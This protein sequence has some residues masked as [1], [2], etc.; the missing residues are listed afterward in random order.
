[1]KLAFR[2]SLLLF[3]SVVVIAG[4]MPPV[5]AEDSGG[6]FD[7]S[8]EVKTFLKEDSEAAGGGDMGWI[9]TEMNFL[10]TLAA[11]GYD[12]L[13]EK[14]LKMMQ[15]G[16]APVTKRNKLTE[17]AKQYL[18]NASVKLMLQQI[19]QTENIREKMV[20]SRKAI[21]LARKVAKSMPAEKVVVYENGMK[22][23]SDVYLRL[24]KHFADLV[25]KEAPFGRAGDIDKA[26]GKIA[27]GPVDIDVLFD[28]E[29]AKAPDPKVAAQNAKL[30]YTGKNLTK[31]AQ[32]L[33][34]MGFRVALPVHEKINLRF[35]N[36]LE[37]YFASQDEKM[38]EQIQNA[39]KSAAVRHGGR[40]VE[41]QH[42]MESGFASWIGLY[43]Y[44]SKKSREIATSFKEFAGSIVMDYESYWRGDKS[45]YLS[46]IRVLGQE[47][48]PILEE[49]DGIMVE[50]YEE[51]EEDTSPFRYNWAPDLAKML[52]E[53]KIITSKQPESEID[54][55]F[56]RQGIY[57]YLEALIRQEDALSTRVETEKD[58][59]RLAAI[60]EY[61]GEVRKRLGALM[62]DALQPESV[63]GPM[64]ENTINNIRLKL[65]TDS[66]IR[67]AERAKKH[68]QKDNVIENL[69]KALAEC[70]AVVSQTKSQSWKVAAKDMIPHIQEY[71]VKLLGEPLIDLTAML[72]QLEEN[73]NKS[74]DAKLKPNEK[75]DALV[76]T[77]ESGFD[78]I[79]GL[80][81]YPDDKARRAEFLPKALLW[82]GMASIELKDFE[83]AYL[84]DLALVQEFTPMRYPRKKYEGVDKS[85]DTATQHLLFAANQMNKLN[86]SSERAKDL[87][88]LALEDVI[89]SVPDPDPAQFVQFINLKKKR[90]K[91]AQALQFVESI[92]EDNIY[93]RTV[94]LLGAGIYNDKI[95]LSRKELAAV[96]KQLA[97]SDGKG[98]GVSASA[99]AEFDAKVADLQKQIAADRENALSYCKRFHAEHDAAAAKR[100]Q[101]IENGKVFSKSD[102]AV[103]LKECEQVLAA[104]LIPIKIMLDSEEYG[105]VVPRIRQFIQ[106]AS[107]QAN[108]DKDKRQKYIAD[109]TYYL[110]VATY[111]A[112]GHDATVAID[113]RAAALKAAEGVRDQLQKVDTERKYE[114][115][116]ASLLGSGYLKL[117]TDVAAKRAELE[118]GGQDGAALKAQEDEF[119]VSGVK[120]FSRAEGLV[121]RDMDRALQMGEI[122]TEQ[123]MYPQAEA[124]YEK[125]VAFWSDSL[126]ADAEVCLFQPEKGMK[127]LA[128]LSAPAWLPLGKAKDAQTPD[129]AAKILNAFIKTNRCTPENM[130]D[131]RAV[132]DAVKG[133]ASGDLKKNIEQAETILARVGAKAPLTEQA[134]YKLN[135]VVLEAAAPNVLYWSRPVY[136]LPDQDSFAAA[137][138]ELNGKFIGKDGKTKE[139]VL[140]K[141]LDAESVKNSIKEDITDGKKDDNGKRSGGY[142]GNGG[143]LAQTEAKAV[144]DE[145]DKISM[146]RRLS[147]TGLR[148]YVYGVYDDQTKKTTGRQ[149]GYGRLKIQQI[150]ELDRKI[151][152]TALPLRDYLEDMTKALAFQEKLI[153]AKRNYAKAMVETGRYEQALS[154]LE[155]LVDFFPDDQSLQL[156]LADVY[157]AMAGYTVDEKTGKRS[158][159][160]YSQEAAQLFSRGRFMIREVV[161][162][163]RAPADLYYE[164]WYANFKNSVEE[165][166]ARKEAGAAGEKD[167]KVIV[168]FMWRGKMVSKEMPTTPLAELGSKTAADIVRMM[169][170]T[171]P[172]S[173]DAFMKS[174]E[175][176]L[177]K[178]KQ[179][180]FEAP[181][182][183][184]AAA[185]ETTEATGGEAA[186]TE[187]N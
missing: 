104:Q 177:E 186:E 170:F 31:F 115:Q 33:Y 173:P 54:L 97:G 92:P 178:L 45:L 29:A 129:E 98:A 18:E 28:P 8:E 72:V 51:G 69:R 5:C 169:G 32:F 130:N 19:E 89:R 10:N 135:R 179:A 123:A 110:F 150:L 95:S 43:P 113:K 76:A 152:G 87:Y 138:D 90:G 112:P 96:K 126:F 30:D 117:G 26:E 144:G 17:I 13:A 100:K 155:K 81:N 79:D 182:I 132:L 6:G 4:V 58:A 71:A 164:G 20:M 67:F 34:D 99:K 16:E 86:P 156:S 55:S 120:W 161:M 139:A 167:Y 149:Y 27:E 93:R 40:K 52:F 21:G 151:D 24:G 66:Y 142:F 57:Y 108:I 1:M 181:K 153:M 2:S 184:A 70:G 49:V 168:D 187:T 180:G 143:I 75:N 107:T 125:A 140:M 136:L 109:G 159:R 134:Y 122:Y 25:E 12:D 59:A 60:K 174:C 148:Q 162:K 114:T 124:M 47:Y 82:T 85:F 36:A 9:D 84:A 35:V 7:S 74:W 78:L 73:M 160:P 63:A 101:L 65:R 83:T 46:W 37:L 88:E 175:E 165:T 102:E 61:L 11:R 62:H 15:A 157:T 185:D 77:V 147:A 146:I 39:L 154:Y 106:T 145:K 128:A 121:Y 131:Y 133:S 103:W 56:R 116:S 23:L 111:M 141:M 158:R 105:E 48:I 163:Q 91:F 3:V 14:Y 94:L 50:R 166:L 80:K 137:V 53:K 127:D 44:G 38:S 22:E 176:L 41:I 64:D 183:E 172:P 118:A 68:D 119:M 42:I 171:N